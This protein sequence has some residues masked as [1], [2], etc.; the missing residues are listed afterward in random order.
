MDP[1][2]FDRLARLAGAGTSRRR[3]LAALG[4]GALA[5]LAGV[6][7]GEAEAARKRSVG[8]SCSTNSDCAS[9]LC[10]QESRTRKVCHC[11]SAADCP[12]VSGQCETAACLPSGYCG[13]AIT[14][15]ASCDDGNACTTGDVCQADGS[16]QGAPVV[17]VALDQCHLPGTCD[18]ATGQCSNPNATDGAPCNDGDACT[19]SDA[20][21]AGV[22]VGSNPVSCPPPDACHWPGVCNQITGL[23][24][25]VAKSDNTLCGADNACAHD[26]CLGG[27]CVP[28]VPKP[29]GTPCSDGNLCTQQDACDATGQ[30]VSGAPA[31]C[32]PSDDCH[33]AGSCDSATGQCLPGALKDGW[34]FIGGVCVQATLPNPVNPC[35]VCMPTLSRTTY[36]NAD[37]LPCDDGN[38]CTIGDTCLAG[39]CVSGVAT[40]ICPP[41]P[42]ACHLAGVCNPANGTCDYPDAANGTACTGG[43]CS[44]GV[45]VPSGGGGGGGCFAA[46]ARVTLADGSTTPIEAVRLGDLVRG[47][48]GAVNTVLAIET[49]LLGD[50]PLHALNGGAAFVT[51]SHPFQTADGP[52]SIDP[53]ATLRETGRAVGQLRPGDVMLG[54]WNARNG[55]EP[56]LDGHA[57]ITLETIAAQVFDWSTQLYNLIV[58]GDGSHLIEGAL[59]ETKFF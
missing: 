48:G 53:A 54:D 6:F 28:N 16:C 12:A 27:V 39:S 2:R 35:Q 1:Q 31:L 36:S 30:C 21:Q 59:M 46:G 5:T 50:R 42:D 24:D 10:V 51:A 26:V 56:G 9:G 4:G 57:P 49:P 8:N 40:V 14:P 18:P 38:A 45:C 34:C 15:G 11:A 41:P 47:R 19:Q 37:G 33:E 7:G 3:L 23:C 58:S 29:L 44:A 55:A 17:C 43:T 25:Y 20:C 13:A 52:K 32:P 22:C